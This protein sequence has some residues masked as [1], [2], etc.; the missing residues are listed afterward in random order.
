MDDTRHPLKRFLIPVAVS[1]VST[2]GVFILLSAFHGIFQDWENRT[3]DVRFHLR[4]TIPVDPRIVMVD[5]DDRSFQEI[6]RWPWD[7]TYH[8]RMIAILSESGASVIGYDVLF[9]QPADKPQ[10]GALIEATR[11]AAGTRSAVL[12]LGETGTGKELFAR[13]IHALSPRR[14]A[15]FVTVNIPAIPENLIESE[16]FGHIK[17]AFTGA[18]SDKKGRFEIAHGGTLFLDEIGEMPPAL[19]AKLLRA[20]Q[21]GDIDRVGGGPVRRVDVR[22]IAA[23]HRDLEAGVRAGTFREDLFYR[24]NVIPLTLLPLRQRTEDLAPLA[25]FFTRKA[26]L[27]IKR[28]VQGISPRGMQVLQQRPWRGNVRELENVLT[29]AV[30]LGSGEWITE[31]DLEGLTRRSEELELSDPPGAGEEAFRGDDETFL[32]LLRKN[33]FRIG[34]AA[35]ALGQSRGTV[36]AR[37]K[38]ICLETLAREGGDSSLAARKITGGRDGADFVEARIREYHDNLMDLARGF[39]TVAAATEECRRRYKN[40]PQRYFPGMEKL[41]QKHFDYR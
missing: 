33:R 32:E 3:V 5:I 18:V 17:G 12:L 22:I 10:D 9:S 39:K 35:S 29:R 14:E 23:T 1:L 11:K 36:A 19:Q 16:L 31:G 6:G 8:A 20:L 4:G 28:E 34:E 30:I 13:A 21:S 25:E 37:F 27:E 41:V 24:L 40:I 7:R 2:L 15:P 38:G 26:A